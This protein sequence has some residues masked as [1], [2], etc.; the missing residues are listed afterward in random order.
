M[1]KIHESVRAMKKVLKKVLKKTCGSLLLLVMLISFSSVAYSQPSCPIVVKEGELVRLSPEAFDPDPEI[2]PAGQL[3]WEFGPPFDS[4]GRWQ[5]RKGQRGIFSFWVSVSDGELKDTVRS[6]V[7]VLPDNRAP[8]LQPVDDITITRG[9]SAKI[10]V[11]CHDPDGD[12]VTVS[13]IFDGREVAY[14]AYEPPGSYDLEVV[15]SDGFG[16]VDTESAKL[17]ILMP[18]PE[19]APKI[20][21]VWV[22]P[23]EQPAPSEVEVK[24]PSSDTGEVEVVMP[25]PADAGEVEV[26]L[27]GTEGAGDV[28]VVYP[29]ECE[30]C[31]PCP[32]CPPCPPC[33]P[34]EDVDVV[35]YDTMEDVGSGPAPARDP[36]EIIVG[37]IPVKGQDDASA[38][39]SGCEDDLKR[40]A[41][42]DE[43]LGCC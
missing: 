21:H 1:K 15:C 41:E 3:L 23:P 39:R 16:G 7:E 33:P 22:P 17:H 19:P 8:V 20:K 30:P 6:C 26:V 35:I 28:D 4:Q 40:K 36:G 38:L 12:P 29:A 5:T 9:E 14:I 24:M 31:P 27:P 34:E 25:A 42:V 13:Y 43:M 18:E 11:S 37:N 10:Q 32:S 2:G